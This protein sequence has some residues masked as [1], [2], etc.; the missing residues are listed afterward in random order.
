MKSPFCFVP[1][2][3]RMMAGAV[4]V[5]LLEPL[6]LRAEIAL[7]AVFSD[8][9]V[10]QRDRPIA[11]W[12]DG[13]PG[14]TVDVA[15]GESHAQTKADEGGRWRLD[16]ASRPASATPAELVVRG[17]K[18]TITVHD[19]L[20]GEVWLC[21]G[22]SNMEKP[23]G[24]QR[25]QKPTL[26]YEEELRAADFPRIRLLK[27]TKTRVQSP[28]REVRGTWVVCSP[29][30]LDSSKFSAAGYFFGRKIF[31]ELDVPVGLIDSTWGG[32]RIEPWTPPDAF[33]LV[34]SLAELALAAKTPGKKAEGTVPSEL[35][36]GMIAPLAPFSLRGFLWYQGETN[37]MDVWDG[38]R[39]ADKMEALVRG[40]RKAWGDPDLAFYYVQLAPHVY[41]IFRQRQV[42]SPEELPKVWEA[43][44][45]SLRIPHTG[46]V[47][48]TDLVDDLF[49]IHPRN[50]RE[51]G[52]RLARLALARAYGRK[53]VVD[54][55][56]VFRRMEIHD[57]RALV[58][59]DAV[60]GGLVAKNS[61]PLSWF[62]IA[63]ADGKFFPA[64]AVIEDDHLVVSSARVP[65]PAVVR[66]A[67]DEAAQPNLF[68][69]AGLPAVPFRTDNPFLA[70][71]GV[72]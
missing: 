4:A 51:V 29:A 61:Q 25:G 7:P 42:V 18:N 55:G 70:E 16:L 2:G 66:F 56:P 35:Y 14:E 3:N 12:G 19:V 43:Q 10:L 52:E 11:I 34:P 45:A 21:S 65:A 67:W 38:A 47:V 53:D 33:E 64:N 54:S 40:W 68:N 60:A 59:F 50:K 6:L 24:E 41:H 37:V 46:M 49:D 17:E 44:T 20:V 27:F 8:H 36:Y 9:V 57:G 63:G 28:A 31:Q 5:A 48:T 32:T 13:A 1:V 62:V 72:K 71:Q 23:V 69:Q 58:Y 22:Q 15:L 39:Y 26:N 30:S